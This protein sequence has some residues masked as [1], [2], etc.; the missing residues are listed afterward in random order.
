MARPPAPPTTSPTSLEKLPTVESRAGEA[1]PNA[2]QAIH[3]FQPTLNFARPYT[4]DILNALTKL[5]QV[6]GYYDGAGHYVRASVGTNLFGYNSATKTLEPISPSD[7]F[8]AFGS[9]APA[10]PVPGRRDPVRAGQLQPVRQPAMG[11]Q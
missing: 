11:L 10:E 7:N 1:F 4:P 9:A 6:T 8:G 2:S 3:D 5:G